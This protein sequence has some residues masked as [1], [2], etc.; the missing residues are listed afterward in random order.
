[1]ALALIVEAERL[2]GLDDLLLVAENALVLEDKLED[3]G[4]GVRTVNVVLDVKGANFVG[5]REALDLAIGDGTH[6]RRLAGTVATAQTVA[7]STLETQVGRVEQDL[8][9][10]GERKL[11]VAQV[12]AFILVLV[13]IVVTVGL[14]AERSKSSRAMEAGS[15]EA[16]TSSRY[17]ARAPSQAGTSKLRAASRLMARRAAYWIAG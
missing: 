15:G 5:R 12:L 3:R 10:I 11:A 14:V 7:V 6:E 4:V 9:T 17:G 13:A 16:V 8:G 2:E 1:V